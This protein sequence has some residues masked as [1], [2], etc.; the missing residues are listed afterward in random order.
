MFKANRHY[1]S[2]FQYLYDFNFPFVKRLELRFHILE[3]RQTTRKLN[4]I[5]KLGAQLYRRESQF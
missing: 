3:R 1:T 5:Q 4:K 2:I